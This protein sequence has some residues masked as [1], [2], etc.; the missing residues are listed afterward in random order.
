MPLPG[1]GTPS[2]ALLGQPIDGGPVW[3]GTVGS[4]VPGATPPDLRF[5]RPPV[6]GVG[7]A[8]AGQPGLPLPG[9]QA[10]GFVVGPAG[11]YG[12]GGVLGAD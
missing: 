7:D 11:G 6:A 3:V 4:P 12:Y 1:H 2:I 5:S 10:G 9:Q 8:Y